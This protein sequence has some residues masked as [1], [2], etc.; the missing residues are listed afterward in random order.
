MKKKKVKLGDIK[1]GDVVSFQCAPGT[2][3]YGVIVSRIMDGHVAELCKYFGPGPE[4][5]PESNLA[6]TF[7][8]P[9]ILDAFSLIE[10]AVE[11]DWRIV[12]HISN[13]LPDDRV[14]NIRFR[15]GVKGKQSTTDIHNHHE[16]VSDEEAAK[17][18]NAS[19][20]GD[21]DVKNY[22]KDQGVDPEL[23]GLA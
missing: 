14:S 7:F 6:D 10:K 3:G 2:F 15:W 19:P 1:S 20:S 8:P 17:W 13:Y 23:L 21:W 5:P 4:M 12:G 22:L 11:G 16:K 18:P 9:V